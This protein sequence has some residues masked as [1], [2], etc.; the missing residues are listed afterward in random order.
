MAKKTS[1]DDESIDTNELTPE[2]SE[3]REIESEDDG[4]NSISNEKKEVEPHLEV[5]KEQ[6]WLKR[7]LVW[8]WHKKFITI[9]VLILLILAVLFA[10]QSTRLAMTSWFWKESF[11]VR[12]VDATNNQPI[13][14]V[15]VK[16][17]GVPL[18]TDTKGRIEMPNFPVGDYKIA[19]EKKYYKSQNLNVALDWFSGNKTYDIKLTAT[20]RLVPVVV[21]DR[22]TGKPVEGSLVSTAADNQVRTNVEGKATIVVPADKNEVAAKV[23]NDKYLQL[24]TQL[25]QKGP[26]QLHV[27]PVGSVYFLS[28][29]SGKIDVVKTNLDGSGRKIVFAGSGFE[30]D[31][32][33]QLLAATDWKYLALKSKRDA[34][35]PAVI[36]LIS[37]ADD[38]VSAIDEGN[39]EF[40]LVGWS[41]HQ[42]VYQVA[43][44]DIA[45]NQEKRSAL[46][47]FNAESKKLTV[48]DENKSESGMPYS[49]QSVFETIDSPYIVGD[50]V[51]Y[52]KSWHMQDGSNHLASLDKQISVI[53]VRSDGINKKVRR[54]FP[55][56]D[57]SSLQAKQY[58]PEEVYYQVYPTV[59]SEPRY[60]EL[61]GDDVKTADNGAAAFTKAYPTYLISPD[62]TKTFWTEDRDGKKALFI[63]DKNG[64]GGQLFVQQ[65]EYAAY[66][67]LTNN[68]LL[69]QKNGSELYIT[70]VD[71]MK[72]GKAPL[73][74]SDY[75]KSS[76]IYG[77]GSGYGGI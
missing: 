9:P 19:I 65:S 55:S 54:T 74:I 29:L 4:V 8:F 76:V 56:A 38:S 20:G 1:T 60:F 73:K 46:K 57:Y 42:F 48:I 68:Y 49:S 50:R 62:V 63:G 24:D 36:T 6:N 28:K 67:W 75:H 2:S 12:V 17:N 44:N 18:K 14:E 66:G 5:K 15:T 69:V 64:G 61:E 30:E 27:V 51:A 23:T 32:S 13:S 43:R 59:G 21:L 70:S 31:Y 41:G 45:Y 7:F 71:E 10:I 47:T 22:I 35:K 72:A 37:T 25:T 52:V 26:N 3:L 39:A 34:T 16:L 33:T 58:A 53:T 11:A 77:Y 40:T